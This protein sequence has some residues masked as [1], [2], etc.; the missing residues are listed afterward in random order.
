[1]EIGDHD[2][3]DHSLTA[4]Q[5]GRKP[6]FTPRGIRRYSVG[7]LAGIA[8]M[9][10]RKI[11]H[12]DM[13][14]DNVLIC[15]D[16]PKIIDFG[17]SK[18]K[19]V[20]GKGKMFNETW[21]QIGTTGFQAPECLPPL[22]PKI[23]DEKQLAKLDSY[24]VGITLFEALLGP[25]LNWRLPPGRAQLFTDSHDKSVQR[26]NHW[27][28][29]TQNTTERRRLRRDGLLKVAEIVSGLIDQDP[30]NRLSIVEALESLMEY[31]NQRR[32]RMAN[33][34]RTRA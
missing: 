25:R 18:T 23:S 3:G 14:P 32:E 13:K 1:M 30:G 6:A 9:H 29:L 24:A 28:G 12:L 5:A 34:R 20:T 7:I 11:Y 22:V 4:P 31:L 15:E 8:H 33:R 19:A 16:V 27:Q 17:L 21:S 2:L 10:Q 26:I